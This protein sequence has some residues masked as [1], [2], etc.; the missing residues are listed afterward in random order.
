VVV[1]PFDQISYLSTYFVRTKGEA[2]D[3]LKSCD[4]ASVFA[5]DCLQ[6]LATGLKPEYYMLEPFSMSS[7]KDIRADL[8]GLMGTKDMNLHQIWD[9][10]ITSKEKEGVTDLVDGNCPIEKCGLP[11]IRACQLCR[12]LCCAGHVRGSDTLFF[13]ETC[14]SI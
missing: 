13:C 4:Y 2:V 11:G 1:P 9:I 10:P 14:W 5:I 12:R 7:P 6:I 3:L 8:A